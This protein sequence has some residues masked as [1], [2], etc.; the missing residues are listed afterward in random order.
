M[1]ADGAFAEVL[2]LDGEHECRRVVAGAGEHIGVHGRMFLDQLHE[3]DSQE[4][5]CLTAVSWTVSNDT[6]RTAEEGSTTF[7]TSRRGYCCGVLGVCV[8]VV[9]VAVVVVLV[10]YLASVCLSTR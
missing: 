1:G 4:H 7:S 10:N 5:E 9:V 8:A 6:V 3:G 2:S